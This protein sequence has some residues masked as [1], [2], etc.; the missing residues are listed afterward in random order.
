[1]HFK[2]KEIQLQYQG[3][4]KTK[5]LWINT[6]YETIQLNDLQSNYDKSFKVNIHGNPRLGKLVEQF[7]FNQFNT[8]ETI[9]LIAE[10]L[11][12][13]D[14]KI[15]IGEIDCILLQN[16]KPIHLEIIYKFYLYDNSVGNSEI[17]HWI[18][19]NRNDS[20]HQKFEKLNQKQL[21]LLYH[22]KTIEVLESYNLNVND[23]SQKVY[24][25]AQLFPHLHAMKNE[26]P[27]INNECIEGFYIYEEELNLFNDC[28]F[29]IPTK[30][31][32]LVQPHYHVNWL[33]FDTF[34]ERL[35]LFLQKKS[36][37]LCWLK[38]NNGELFKIFIV[39]WS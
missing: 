30:H 10:N 19:P 31:N 17:E 8:I 12:I 22:K 20:F 25:K 18:G 29:F 11:Q 1:M 33:N 38:K 13:Q 27:V 16:E 36:S 28:K 35:T 2:N 34:K 9:T 5:S 26:F 15:T 3:F 24:F 14:D 6:L 23:I 37:P 4:L 39:W 7:V 32:W 21:P